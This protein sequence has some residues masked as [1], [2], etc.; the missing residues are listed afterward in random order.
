MMLSMRRALAVRN[1]LVQNGVDP[2]SVSIAA[3]GDLTH[4]MED[5]NAD[6][7]VR[8]VDIAVIPPSMDHAQAGDPDVT[9]IL[10][11]YF[12]RPEGPL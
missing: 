5:G 2:A 9:K 4:N 1:A 12:G 8:R 6:K 10:P 3:L 7:A 11:Q